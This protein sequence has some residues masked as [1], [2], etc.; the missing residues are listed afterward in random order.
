MN[1]RNYS[2]GAGLANGGGARDANGW[3]AV[4]V[5]STPQGGHSANFSPMT[6]HPALPAILANNFGAFN[7]GA[8]R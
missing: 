4:Y 1:W 2:I 3:E 5:Q 6:R 8:L 7:T